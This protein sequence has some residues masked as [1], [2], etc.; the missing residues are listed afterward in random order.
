MSNAVSGFN[1]KREKKRYVESTAYAQFSYQI[2]ILAEFAFFKS[3]L[4]N[5]LLT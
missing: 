4:E 1:K 3:E 5:F 2:N